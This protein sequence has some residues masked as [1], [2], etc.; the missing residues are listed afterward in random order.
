MPRRVRGIGSRAGECVDNAG[1]FLTRFW[2]GAHQLDLVVFATEAFFCGQNWYSRLTALISYLRRQQNLVNEMQG[3]CP[4]FATILWLSLGKELPWF[5]K[6]RIRINIYLEKKSPLCKPYIFCGGSHCW[7]HAMLR[8]SSTFSSS[9]YKIAPSL[10]IIRPLFLSG[11]SIHF[12]RSS[13]SRAPLR[14]RKLKTGILAVDFSAV[15]L[16]YRLRT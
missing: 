5:A 12:A 13:S 3:K 4:K 15:P 1:H 16:L 9:L 6:H 14:H 7:P 10:R 11:S 8:T 2:C